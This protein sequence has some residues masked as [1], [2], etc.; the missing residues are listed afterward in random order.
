MTMSPVLEVVAHPSGPWLVKAGE[1]LY[2]VPPGL[3]RALRPLAGRRPE[4]QELR[5]S[6]TGAGAGPVEGPLAME[7]ETW[8]DELSWALGPGSA[9]K[10]GRKKRRRVGR[11]I[12]FR[13][14]L[15]PGRWVRPL[16]ERGQFLT[17]NRSLAALTFLGATGYLVAGS[18]QVGFSWDL[19]TVAAGLGLFLLSAIWHEL[20]HAAALAR[21][22]YPA[23]GIGAG[24]LFVVPVLFADVTAVG[25]LSRTGRLR[26]DVSGVVF[27]LAAGGLFMGVASVPGIPEAAA[28][29][30]ALAGSSALL[31]V[32][33]SLFPFIRSDGYW[34]LCDFL[35]LDDLDRP[36]ANRPRPALRVFLVVYQL[37][38]AVFL[39]L[40]GIY[41]PWRILGLVLGLAHHLG[42]SQGSPA[43]KWLAGAGMVAFLGMMGLGIIRKMTALTRSAVK[44][45]RGF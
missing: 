9:G 24:I 45:A 20:G 41:F 23:G 7:I 30:L 22:G 29:V 8:V 6:L 12:R 13:V 1:F 4:D 34:L 43:A 17:G 3:G 31:A 25:V 35:G 37:A 15:I 42:V 5:A 28:Q 40:I 10:T 2:A 39:L 36:P 32:T 38:N 33:W 44:V 18:G 19:G 14:P 21:S 16:A 27:Q 26:V 11:P